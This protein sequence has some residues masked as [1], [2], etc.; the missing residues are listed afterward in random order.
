MFSFNAGRPGLCSGKSASKTGIAR[1]EFRT[2][3]CCSGHHHA[4]NSDFSAEFDQV[5]AAILAVSMRLNSSTKL[6]ED[7]VKRG[8]GSGVA[9]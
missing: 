5:D 9:R 8:N 4:L 1:F 6:G 2:I 7:S 3:G